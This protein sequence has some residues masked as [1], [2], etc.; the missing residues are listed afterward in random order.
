VASVLRG[1]F[2][3]RAIVG[4]LLVVPAM[5][6]ADSTTV[7][8]EL[9]ELALPEN[10]GRGFHP[11]VFL[12]GVSGSTGVGESAVAVGGELRYRG[13]RCDYVRVGGQGRLAYREGTQTSMEQWASA[14]V[15]I[16]IMELGHHLEWDVR[17]SLLASLGLRPGTNRRETVAF[18]WQPLRAPFNKLLAA[19]EA[20]EAKKQGIKLEHPIDPDDPALPRGDALVF[21]TRV[22][23]QIAWSANGEP[24]VKD[25]AEVISFGYIKPRLA[26]WGE[27]R[28]FSIEIFRGGGE[29]VDG[30]RE[31]DHTATV[32]VWILRLANIKLGP[33]FATAGGGIV[34]GSAGP[35][36][37]DVEREVSLTTGRAELGVET[38]GKYVHGYLR[39]MRDIVLA[40]DGYGYVAID[41]RATGGIGIELP[42]GRIGLEGVLAKDEIHAPGMP[43]V[44][45]NTGG[46]SLSIVQRLAPYVDATL[47][48]DVAR[49]FYASRT[50][51]L[52]F[53]PRWGT[54]VFAGLQAR[55]RR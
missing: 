9:R 5:A 22:D 8:S 53:V 23:F 32:G 15:P 55:A 50:D 48:L 36:V 27:A 18:H 3:M 31:E 1:A 12:Q 49:S 21:D 29:F 30:R 44:R 28:D 54:N 37:S 19:I 14:C 42:R 13:T 41:N 38:G 40:T 43:T 35:F 26:A 6:V 10:P 17:P 39:G 52:D 7:E 20:G 34:S 25:K 46:G 47:R 51:Q 16:F 4:I 2:T 11:A 24:V 33:V 45:A